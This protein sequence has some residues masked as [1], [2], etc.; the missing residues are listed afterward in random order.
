M[1]HLYLP[2][3]IETVRRAWE[4]WREANNS[5]GE[6]IKLVE[7]QGGCYLVT[8][9]RPPRVFVDLLKSCMELKTSSL[10]AVR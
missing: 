7:V 4:D 2:L 8:A 9:S 1:K 6:A 3:P 5:G 10:A